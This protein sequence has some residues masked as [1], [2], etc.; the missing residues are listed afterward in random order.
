MPEI[1]DHQGE[2]ASERLRV[3]AELARQGVVGP[4]VASTLAHVR[5]SRRVTITS[6]ASG[7]PSSWAVT[8]LP[9]VVECCGL[10]I[11][12]GAADEDAPVFADDHGDPYWQSRQCDGCGSRYSIDDGDFERLT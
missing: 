6:R 3:A 11:T 2:F 4:E 9:R 7:V 5:E 12:V 8:W 1:H 10:T